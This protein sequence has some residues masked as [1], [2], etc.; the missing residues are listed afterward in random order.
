MH[1]LVTALTIQYDVEIIFLK[2]LPSGETVFD[3]SLID[4]ILFVKKKR[5]RYPQVKV[6]K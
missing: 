2:Y 5:Q 1:L 6:Y 3:K 4:T